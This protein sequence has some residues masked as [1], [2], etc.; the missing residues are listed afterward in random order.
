MEV[1]GTELLYEGLALQLGFESRPT[2][3]QFHEHVWPVIDTIV[4][5]RWDLTPVV[6]ESSGMR[7]GS[8]APILGL[9]P[10]ASFYVLP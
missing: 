7:A 2:L 9:F 1:Q 4:R 8:M 5:V 6:D 3:E 10:P